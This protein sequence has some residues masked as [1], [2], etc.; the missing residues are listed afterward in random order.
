VLAV[1]PPL[2]LLLSVVVVLP[3][4][5]PSRPGE[6][7]LLLPICPPPTTGGNLCNSGKRKDKGKKTLIRFQRNFPAL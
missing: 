2:L 5:H 1:P 4:L 6:S 3:S 7:P